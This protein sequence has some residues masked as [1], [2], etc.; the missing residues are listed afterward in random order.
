MCLAVAADY[1]D[2]VPWEGTVID[3]MDAILAVSPFAAFNYTYTTPMARLASPGS[4]WTATV[5]DVEKRVVDMG[6]SDVRIRRDD[7]GPILPFSTTIAADPPVSQAK[8]HASLR[9]T[10]SPSHAAAVRS[11]G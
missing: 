10:P 2:S 7:D 6:G 9:P 8:T 4:Q 5:Y 3:F 1:D 11:S